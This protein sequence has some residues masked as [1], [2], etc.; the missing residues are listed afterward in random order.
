MGKMERDMKGKS[1]EAAKLKQ[2]NGKLDNLVAQFMNDQADWDTRW[3][4][5]QP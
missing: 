1:K 3:K 5:K 4:N 2:L